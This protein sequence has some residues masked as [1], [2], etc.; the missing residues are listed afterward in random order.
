M[1]RITIEINASHPEFRA[2]GD[3]V[4]Y[5]IYLDGQDITDKVYKVEI[6]LDAPGTH[7]TGWSVVR[8][9]VIGRRQPVV[10]RLGQIEFDNIEHLLKESANDNEPIIWG[11][12]N[13]F[14]VRD[15]TRGSNPFEG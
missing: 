1:S 5:R 14:E 13:I 8:I 2:L 4:R 9:S 6:E 3:E 7:P 12:A 10:A 11:P 15:K